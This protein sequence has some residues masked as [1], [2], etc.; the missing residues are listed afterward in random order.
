MQQDNC[1]GSS[2]G[3]GDLMSFFLQTSLQRRIKG[4]RLRGTAL[5]EKDTA[6][7]DVASSSE[8][9]ETQVT[10]FLS[11]N[12]MKPLDE[13]YIKGVNIS[14]E[15]LYDRFDSD[16]RKRIKLIR[17]MEKILRSDPVY[18]CV[19][20][21]HLG[22]LTTD[23]NINVAKSIVDFVH[24]N[25]DIIMPNLLLPYSIKNLGI[26]K[27]KLLY[28]NSVS[29]RCV[30]SDFRSA[31][32]DCPLE[33]ES[34]AGG[35]KDAG[36]SG[37]SNY[38][39]DSKLSKELK[40]ASEEALDSFFSIISYVSSIIE[41]YGKGY[42]ASATDSGGDELVKI[43][44]FQK[45]NDSKVEVLYKS[46]LRLAYKILAICMLDTTLIETNIK[47]STIGEIKNRLSSECWDYPN[48]SDISNSRK[49]GNRALTLSCLN[50]NYTYIN[51]FN[52]L[53]PIEIFLCGR[54][55]GVFERIV[56]R[57]S[58]SIDNSGRHLL[59]TI[60]ESNYLLICYW[61]QFVSWLTSTQTAY[62]IRF[63]SIIKHVSEELLS[64]DAGSIKKES[65]EDE[66]K[67]EKREHV[68]GYSIKEDF[69]GLNKR[70][71]E[72]VKFVFREELLRILG[73]HNNYN[74]II[75]FGEISSIVNR[76]GKG[77]SLHELR[78]EAV[79]RFRSNGVFAEKD[80]KNALHD[81]NKRRKD[82]DESGVDYPPICTQKTRSSSTKYSYKR[83]RYDLENGFFKVSPQSVFESVSWLFSTKTYSNVIDLAI[84]NFLN[85]KIPSSLLG[86][87]NGN[88]STKEGELL[89]NKSRQS[90]DLFL[91]SSNISWT[92][93]FSPLLD[94]DSSIKLERRFSN[95]DKTDKTG[96]ESDKTD[97]FEF[98]YEL[99]DG[100]SNGSGAGSKVLNALELGECKGDADSEGLSI[101]SDITLSTPSLKEE[102]MNS[103]CVPD[104]E[105]M[106][107]NV[108][109]M[110]A[111]VFSQIITSVLATPVV[112]V[113]PEG[114]Y[115]ASKSLSRNNQLM[116]VLKYSQL[117]LNSWE[118]LL[119]RIRS[120]EN[121]DK[122][123]CNI[124]SYG[125][126][127]G[128]AWDLFKSRIGDTF[129]ILEY[130]YRLLIRVVLSDRIEAIMSDKSKAKLYGTFIDILVKNLISETKE[131]L[132]SIFMVSNIYNEEYLVGDPNEDYYLY[133]DGVLYHDN[134]DLCGI[135][136][137]TQESAEDANGGGS[138]VRAREI[139]VILL[140]WVFNYVLEKRVRVLHNLLFRFY[141]ICSHRGRRLRP[142]LDYWRMFEWFCEDDSCGSDADREPT[143]SGSEVDSIC[144]LSSLSIGE[145][146][147]KDDWVESYNKL[148]NM[149]LNGFVGCFSEH[150]MRSELFLT[151]LKNLVL[152]GPLVP[153]EF[154]RLLYNQWIFQKSENPGFDVKMD[155]GDGTCSS[156]QTT[157][158]V[159]R[160]FAVNIILSVLNSN[161]PLEHLRKVSFYALIMAL[162][163][164]EM[165]CD[166]GTSNN[167][168][169][170]RICIFNDKMEDVT[171][172]AGS[173]DGGTGEDPVAYPGPRPNAFAKRNLF[174][175]INELF[176]FENVI[177]NKKI[178]IH[179]SRKVNDEI[180]E[181]FNMSFILAGQDE[182]SSV[183]TTLEN[184]VSERSENWGN[185][186]T[187][188]EK[189]PILVSFLLVTGV[190]PSRVI[191]SDLKIK[192]LL[193][194][195]DFILAVASNLTKMFVSEL[196][197]KLGFPSHGSI[198]QIHSRFGFNASDLDQPQGA[199]GSGQTNANAD[200]IDYTKHLFANLSGLFKYYCLKYP[201]LINLVIRLH[202]RIDEEMGRIRNKDAHFYLNAVRELYSGLFG[203]LVGLFKIHYSDENGNADVLM[204]EYTKII[205]VYKRNTNECRFVYDFMLVILNNASL[206]PNNRAGVIDNIYEIFNATQ[207]INV[208][209]PV[210]GHYD[211]NRIKE[212][213]P[214]LIN[215]SSKSTMKECIRNIITSQNNLN[216]DRVISSSELLIL[217]ISFSHP[218][219]GYNIDKRK[220]VDLVD[221]CFELTQ[222]NPPLFESE[223]IASVIGK[224]VQDN[225]SVFPRTLG[226]ALVLSVLY[227]PSIR[228]FIATFVVSSLIRN[229]SVWE[230]T[231]TWRGVRHCIQ[232]LWSD[233]KTSIFPSLILL[234]Q[235]EFKS[236]FNELIEANSE[237]RADC[238][239]IIKRTV[240]LLHH[241][242]HRAS[243]PTNSLFFPLC[244]LES[245]IR[246]AIHSR[247]TQNMSESQSKP[248]FVT[249]KA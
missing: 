132:T 105:D 188:G 149:C 219:G 16:Y 6:G 142:E 193:A 180:S 205:N 137:I 77:G 236:V 128:S 28:E 189:W 127:V 233:Y 209:V 55:I 54:C 198:E 87:E 145:R 75:L 11:S 3:G 229:C 12:A 69:G 238:L 88:S 35:G 64:L 29:N 206:T 43:C 204:D 134:I 103:I 67:P 156:S 110:K 245:E 200:L 226:R 109:S 129:D 102:L 56:K 228:P 92:N 201:C 74:N 190:V 222:S 31:M 169:L 9:R 94:P 5:L 154:L 62:L 159:K 163:R 171:V 24:D 83:I 47:P 71:L 249:L 81:E 82:E 164:S 96:T 58:A 130:K 133:L 59:Y 230:D 97:A 32:S 122:V 86:F 119:R 150:K 124:E 216:N 91:N 84:N 248:L 158:S 51:S 213:L 148:F 140:L 17:C 186:D 176:L 162:M 225:K 85:V 42:H 53:M 15:M 118:L 36:N 212:L 187:F 244:H 175:F 185:P 2:D 72:A 111:I 37:K 172:E 197:A 120:P 39:W 1:G 7:G 135:R 227:I 89:A 157:I 160:D 108:N 70:K 98:N 104:Y 57:V 68:F 40:L 235:T 232:K 38:W 41:T 240:S 93:R 10:R 147:N 48:N 183:Y 131:L 78:R 115:T 21:C 33:S 155:D 199:S 224:F 44:Y 191:S 126:D 27:D 174:T 211:L 113:T 25:I 141:H 22:S 143:G 217:L 101:K 242:L 246:A 247:S 194:A 106:L 100:A 26:E 152:S 52:C 166:I 179:E 221:S 18:T 73:S 79:N 203:E 123:D 46:A 80:A 210:I 173:N 153:I 23:L 121:R 45:D 107:K 8:T 146:E 114:V 144:L 192:Q 239:E 65:V 196:N 237:L 165:L 60:K 178:N 161:Y 112:D 66:E 151:Q 223:T 168:F 90:S 117:A 19:V 14:N 139:S 170:G 195:N 116:N 20:V 136:E 30:G 220:A 208:V 218:N 125:K 167:G 207:D 95:I 138:G 184:L 234:P 243:Q 241:S 99:G 202:S 76:L 13:D 50:G 231:L 214:I 49:S 177:H 63:S 4:L 181:T 61:I 34:K 215:K 182:D